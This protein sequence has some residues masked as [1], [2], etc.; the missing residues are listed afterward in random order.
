MRAVS[1]KSNSKPAGRGAAAALPPPD[2]SPSTAPAG[3]DILP[4]DAA[5]LQRWFEAMRA[6]EASVAATIALTDNAAGELMPVAAIG[7]EGT[8][9]PAILSVAVSARDKASLQLLPLRS[10]GRTAMAA[11]LRAARKAVVV[12]VLDRAVSDASRFAPSFQ[13]SLTRLA[14]ALE[15]KGR[16]AQAAA[17]AGFSAADALALLKLTD[18]DAFAR[19]LYARIDTVLKPDLACLAEVR[20]SR[21]RLLRSSAKFDPLPRGGRVGHSR[22][23]ALISVA[24]ADGAL[25]TSW[26]ERGLERRTNLDL[27]M[28]CSNEGPQR[29]I[30]AALPNPFGNGRLV[31]LGEYLDAN[32]AAVI[33]PGLEPGLADLGDTIT[34]LR[35]KGRRKNA[36]TE[37]RPWLT[38]R[39]LQIGAVLAAAAVIVWLC[40][41]APLNIT[42]EATLNSADQRSI[43]AP[44]DGILAKAN[45]EPGQTVHKGDVLAEFDTRE[46]RLRRG[47][48]EAQLAQAEARKQ[49][50]V[51]SFKAADIAV[52]DAEIDALNAQSDLLDLMLDQSRIVAA[53]DTV[54]LSGNMSERVGSSLRKGELMF[55][56]APLTGYSVS[57]D[58]AQQ[59]IN[60]LAIGQH[61]SLKLTAMPFDDFPVELERISPA[62]D[63]AS[64]TSAF[65]V[66]AALRADNPLFRPGMKGVA[67]IDAGQTIRIWSLSR[68]VVFWL[69]M[70]LWRW[71]P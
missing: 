17:P 62:A 16:P 55:T 65:N 52:V 64:A 13:L 27:G 50:A 36:A 31:F 39:L 49:T 3:D 32:A 35:R 66:R 41:P 2:Q 24:N 67:H 69:R 51:A 48:I 33:D 15:Q 21:I 19:A 29:A 10:G 60:T 14:E 11:P 22:R 61:G 68:D 38:R 4:F 8:P 46:L 12:L 20:G 70:Q 53:E 63:D 9:D 57:I 59:D 71:I 56:L 37:A 30:A 7:L 28:L 34:A 40:L 25:F 47:S 6:A 58:V 5:I 1:A 45:F 23:T 18:G 44:G 54:V 42:G 26:A 43:V